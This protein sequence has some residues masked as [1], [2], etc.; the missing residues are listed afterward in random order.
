MKYEISS[1]GEENVHSPKRR[2]TKYSEIYEHI[3]G[4]TTGDVIKIDTTTMSG[5]AVNSLYSAIYQW[6]KRNKLDNHIY[7]KMQENWLLIVREV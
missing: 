3:L 1:I 5:V 2:K 7:Q 4:M 6:L